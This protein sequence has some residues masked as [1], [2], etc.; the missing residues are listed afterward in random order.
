MFSF[1]EGAQEPPSLSFCSLS[2]EEIRCKSPQND[3]GIKE[4]TTNSGLHFPAM[5]SQKLLSWAIFMEFA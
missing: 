5:D 1:R 3:L 4:R 2:L